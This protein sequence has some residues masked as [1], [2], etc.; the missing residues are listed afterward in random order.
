[1]RLTNS[2][3]TITFIKDNHLFF[4][5]YY[6]EPVDNLQNILLSK[7][8][9]TD[10]TS[11]KYITFG[12]KFNQLVNNLPDSILG[13]KFKYCFDQPVNNFPQNLTSLE[14]GDSFNQPINDLPNNLTFLKFGNS[15]N[16]PI[17]NLPNGLTYLEFGE[18]FYQCVDNL[19]TTLQI[20][21]FFY[22]KRAYEEHQPS[23]TANWSRI[24]EP[25]L[26]FTDVIKERNYTL[27]NLPSN[28]K[29]LQLNKNYLK[30]KVDN[31]PIFLSE[32][33]APE[34]LRNMIDKI[35]FGCNLTYM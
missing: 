26:V 10:L 16:Q 12:I 32:L 18:N 23:G 34:N 7:S 2:N 22:E 9:N 6:N 33:R 21:I 13:I 14:F 35:P 28:L 25:M 3:N 27:N 5:D 17:D 1:M 19:P 20:L 11:I 31:L 24:S 4:D 8:I 15:F 29:Q 30:N